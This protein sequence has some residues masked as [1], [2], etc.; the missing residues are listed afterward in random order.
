MIVAFRM[1]DGPSIGWN[2]VVTAPRLMTTRYCDHMILDR[3]DTV[4]VRVG[5]FENLRMWDSR[6]GMFVKLRF[7]DC[8]FVILR[9][10]DLRVIFSWDGWSIASRIVTS[11]I[12]GKYELDL[13]L[14]EAGICK[15]LWYFEYLWIYIF[16]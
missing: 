14:I 3:C 16:E 1:I 4:M 13:I 11:W 9:I 15:Y 5:D 6:F 12:I 8:N 7:C 10:W 2:K